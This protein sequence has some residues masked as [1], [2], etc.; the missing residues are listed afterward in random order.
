[1]ICISDILDTFKQ[2]DRINNET[3]HI[4]RMVETRLPKNGIQLLTGA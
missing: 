3:G 1:M 2:L 4:E